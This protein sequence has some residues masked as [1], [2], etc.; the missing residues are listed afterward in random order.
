MTKHLWF[1]LVASALPLA[2]SCGGTSAETDADFQKDVVT[3]M[4]DSISVQL[5]AL[6]S[7][8]VDLQTAAPTHAWDATADADA[9]TARKAAWRRTR[10]AYE[11]VEGATAP[12]FPQFDNSMDARYDDFLSGNAGVEL[13]SDGDTTPF[14]GSGITGMHAIERILYANVIP[15]D[16]VA[17]EETLPGYGS[18]SFPLTDPDAMTFKTGICQ[19][20]IDDANMLHD[21]WVP[22]AIDLGGSYQGLVSLMNEQKEKVDLA[23]S[24]Q[25]ESR[26]SQL[27]LFDLRNNL[28]GTE[29]IYALFQP[30]IAARSKDGSENTM[31]EAGFAKLDADY[32]AV[33]GD[34][35]PPTPPDW[36]SDMPTTADLAT[37][38]GTLWESVH[39]AVDPTTPG[40]VVYEMNAV[41][42]L[43]GFPQFVEQ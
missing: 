14:D 17:F 5:A 24:G 37:P 7:A 31:I 18:A 29:N 35:I 22:S 2:A 43:L 27:T 26:Y 1:A 12:I 32:T 23:S 38:F 36:S 9:I 8:A 34:A 42:T 6:G 13:G 3:G 28:M 21:Q 30:W 40:S 4:H 20:L 39:E 41:A 19:R 11:L 33:S 10:V 15:A 25:E 16:V